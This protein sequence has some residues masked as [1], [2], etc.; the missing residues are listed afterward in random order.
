MMENVASTGCIIGDSFQC[1]LCDALFTKK[2]RYESHFGTKR[3]KSNVKK[4]RK[5]FLDHGFGYVSSLSPQINGD[6]YDYSDYKGSREIFLKNCNIQ[7]PE[8]SRSYI[9]SAI[10]YWSVDLALNP[11]VMDFK[12]SLEDRISD[13]FG[14][15]VVEVSFSELY[16]KASH[17]VLSLMHF[18]NIE[19]NV[20]RTVDSFKEGPFSYENILREIG[21]MNVQHKPNQ[22][23]SYCVYSTCQPGLHLDALITIKYCKNCRTAKLIC[24]CEFGVDEDLVVKSC[25]LKK[26]RLALLNTSDYNEDIYYFY[27][28]NPGTYPLPKI[29]IYFKQRRRKEFLE[30]ITSLIAKQL[31]KCSAAQVAE[32]YLLQVSHWGLKKDRLFKVTKENVLATLTGLLLEPFRLTPSLERNFTTPIK[33]LKLWVQATRSVDVTVLGSQRDLDKLIMPYNLILGKLLDVEVV[34]ESIQLP[35]RALK[36]MRNLLLKS[37]LH[38]EDQGSRSFRLEL[39]QEIGWKAGVVPLTLQA[40][41]PERAKTVVRILENI[42]KQGFFRRYVLVTEYAQSVRTHQK[43]LSI[44]FSL[45][46]IRDKLNDFFLEEVKIDFA[47][48]HVSLQTIDQT[49]LLFKKTITPYEFF[50]MILEKSH[51]KLDTTT[52]NKDINYK[53]VLE[54]QLFNKLRDSLQLEDDKGRI[55]LRELSPTLFK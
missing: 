27:N 41:D 31:Y 40:E 11:S 2:A 23:I 1:T 7:L 38:E 24:G 35:K 28:E 17:S 52:R 34:E 51:I 43:Y 54:S 55:M 37:Y 3:H 19:S 50:C 5:D 29:Y 26:E 47:G 16:A 44:F 48:E 15:A 33:K 42:K 53:L 12:I 39:L 49:D 32:D 21:K 22:K 25:Y 4:K 30:H 46:D 20:A 45:D 9:L 36:N 10:A 13:Y 6:L 18:Q 14:E 8:M